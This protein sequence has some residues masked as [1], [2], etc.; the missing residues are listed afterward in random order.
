MRVSTPRRRAGLGALLALIVLAAAPTAGTPRA[1]VI[2]PPARSQEIRAL[3]VLRGSLTNPDKIDRLV[4]SAA[5]SGFNTLLLQVRGRGDAYFDSAIEPRGVGV[6]T[7]FDPLAYATTAASKA[8]L[9]VHV[10]FNTNLIASTA[11]MPTSRTHIVNAHPEWLMVPRPIAADLARL[12]PRHPSYV[13]RLV[14]WTK[15]NAAGV[16][17]LYASPVTPDAAQYVERIIT[18]IVTR[19]PIS[20]VHLDYIRYPS[21]LFDHSQASLLAFRDSLQ[22][23]LS[24]SDRQR[25]DDRLRR[26]P[27]VY[28]DAFPERWAAYRRMRLADLVARI[29]GAVTRVRPDALITAAVIPDAREAYEHKL[30]DWPDWARRGLVDAFC[31]MAYTT[32][33]PIFNR[34]VAAARQ[35]AAPRQVWAGIGAYRLT[36]AQTVDHI[37]AA[38][39]AGASGIVLFSYDSLVESAIRDPLGAIGRVAFAPKRAAS[40]AD[41]GP[42]AGPVNVR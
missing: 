11:S 34:Q 37:A 33:L 10:W 14:E 42:D 29:R 13:P 27:L 26:D 6:A 7:T 17:G 9:R 4:A 2:A 16:E 15:R 18:D 5:R 19:Y 30:Q 38:R 41:R 20:G 39:S 21:N 32:S 3:W 23:E 12:G 24:P 25:L 22:R 31:P 36:P 40:D 8:G 1:S 28:A 35:A